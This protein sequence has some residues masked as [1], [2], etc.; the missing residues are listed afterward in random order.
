MRAENGRV[1]GAGCHAALDEVQADGRVEGG[2][3]GSGGVEDIACKPPVTGADLDQ[4]KRWA[5]EQSP[6][7]GELVRQQLTEERSQIGARKKVARATGPPVGAGVISELRMVKRQ[8]H[9]LRERERPA[10]ADPLDDELA[11][12]HGVTT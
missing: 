4:V 11:E 5:P 10:R 3:R 1:R 9:V 12:R 2:V 8:L 7:V 6:H